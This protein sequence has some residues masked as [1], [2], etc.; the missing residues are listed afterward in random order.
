[1][2]PMLSKPF[3]RTAIVPVSVLLFVL[4]VLSGSPGTFATTTVLFLAGTVMTTMLFVFCR[5]LALSYWPAS[6]VTSHTTNA[7]G[8]PIATIVSGN[9]TTISAS[10][11]TSSSR[12]T[13]TRQRDA[14]SRSTI[15]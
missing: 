12:A 14:V 10:S 4:F 9:S 8:A 7:T 11:I 6:F 5:E 15:Q 1:M 3:S 2:T 13:S